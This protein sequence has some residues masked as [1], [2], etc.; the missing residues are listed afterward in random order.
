MK[1]TAPRPLAAHDH[2][3]S[4]TNNEVRHDVLSQ[5]NPSLEDLPDDLLRYKLLP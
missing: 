1:R 3:I 2:T 5:P 4:D